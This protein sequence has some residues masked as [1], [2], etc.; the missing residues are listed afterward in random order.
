MLHDIF[1]LIYTLYLAHTTSL[2]MVFTEED[3]I[4]VKFLRQNKTISR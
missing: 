4:V 1:T 2:I 3:R